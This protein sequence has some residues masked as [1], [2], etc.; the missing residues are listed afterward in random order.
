MNIKF[1]PIRFNILLPL[2]EANPKSVARSD[3]LQIR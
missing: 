2:N 3:I 1:T